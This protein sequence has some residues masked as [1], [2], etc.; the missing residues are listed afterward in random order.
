MLTGLEVSSVAC[1]CV[2]YRPEYDAKG[3]LHGSGFRKS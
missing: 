1:K 3:I 2:F